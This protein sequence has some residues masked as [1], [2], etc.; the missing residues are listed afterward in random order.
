MW[1]LDR[2]DTVL[3]PEDICQECGRLGERDCTRCAISDIL[4]VLKTEPEVIKDVCGK[5]IKYQLDRWE[6]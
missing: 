4:I 2:I 3:H 6:H 5:R 1:R